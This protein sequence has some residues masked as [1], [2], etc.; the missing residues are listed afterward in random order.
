MVGTWCRR[1]QI[2][3]GNGV[4]VPVGRCKLAGIGLRTNHQGVNGYY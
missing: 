4:C 2:R 1:P 3:D